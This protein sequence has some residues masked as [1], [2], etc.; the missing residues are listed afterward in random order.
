[1]VATINDWFLVKACG[2][3]RTKEFIQTVCINTTIAIAKNVDFITPATYDFTSFA[4]Q[5]ANA[6]VSSCCIFHTCTNKWSLRTQ[7]WYRLTLHVRTHQGT[8]SIVIFKEW[9]HS[10]TDGYNFFWTNVHVVNLIRCN[11]QYVMTT[12]TSYVFISKVT[13]SIDWRV[14]LGNCHAFF[15]ISCH[16]YNGI[17]YTNFY[18]FVCIGA[19]T[20]DFFYFTVWSL[21][22]TEFIYL[23]IVRQG[24]DQTDVWT[25][26]SFNWTHA[27]IVRVMHVTNFEACTLTR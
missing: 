7:E 13:F 1:M 24:V 14:R 17:S 11:F 23:R 5:Y 3:V 8:V 2:L 16:I 6:R 15:F 20:I 9:N 4:C 22:E 18:N 21:N 27:A 12:T 25:F 19:C 10:C 26:W